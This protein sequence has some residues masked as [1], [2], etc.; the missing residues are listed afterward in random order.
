MSNKKGLSEKVKG[1][2]SKTKG[3]FKEQVG[4]ATDNPRLEQEGKTDKARGRYQ[5]KTG[6]FK[7]KFR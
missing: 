5:K 6:E 2:V 4:N 3:E 7:D 1:T